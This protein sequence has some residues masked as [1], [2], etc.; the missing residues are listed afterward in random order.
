MAYIPSECTLQEYEEQVYSGSNNHRLYIKYGDTIIGDEANEYASPF[1]SSLKWTR[2]LLDNGS[3]TFNLD[4]FVSQEI[5]LVLN[6]YVIQDITQEI[7]IKIGTYIEKLNKWVY[8]P[9]GKYLVQDNPTT[10][11]NRTTY[12][13][14]DKSKLFD[15]KYNAEPLITSKGGKATLLEILDDICSQA[16]V[17]YVG[18][19]TFSGYN[20]QIGIYDNT[21][22]ARI[23]VS[24]IAEQSGSIATIDRNGNLTFIKIKQSELTT[25]EVSEDIV[26][27]FTDG[28]NFIISKV[29]YESGIIKY[30]KGNDNND[31]LYINSANPYVSNQTQVDNIYN[32]VN[33]LNINSFAI[34][35]IYGNPTFD[36][37]DLIVLNYEGKTYKTFAQYIFTF[38]GVFTSK[39]ETT[40]EHSAKKQNVSVNSEATFRKY[41]KTTIDNIEAKVNIATGKVEQLE[42]EVT[43]IKETNGNNSLYVEDA[44]ESRVLEYGIDGK[45]EQETRSGKNLLKY[46]Y[47]QTTRTQDGI[48]FTDN[49]DG[50]ITING[51]CTANSYTL[52]YLTKDLW[53]YSTEL[54]PLKA[55]TYTFKAIHSNWNIQIALNA[56]KSDGTNEF[57]SYSNESVTKTFTEDVV[58]NIRVYVPTGVTLNNVTIYPQIEKGSTATEFEQYGASPSPEFPSEIKS[59]DGIKNLWKLP[60]TKT[61]NGVTLTNNGDG[62]ITLNGTATANADFYIEDSS[63]NYINGEK[64]YI[65][66]NINKSDVTLLIANYNGNTYANT[67]INS[68]GTMPFTMNTTNDRVRLI[69]RALS[70]KTFNNTKLQIQ[71]E[72]SSVANSFVPYG[73]WLKIKDNGSNALQKINFY[74]WV[75]N[76]NATQEKI[77]DYIKVNMP[78][79]PGSATGIYF[80]TW[81]GRKKG[82]WKEETSYLEGKEVTFSFYA[83]AD[84]ERTIFYL[85]SDNTKRYITLTTEWKRYSV[86]VTN[87]TNK[88]VPVFYCGDTLSTTSYYIKDIMLQK[89]ELIDY[90]P[91]K[92]NISLI[93]MNKP[94]LFDKNNATLNSGVNTSTGVLY[95]STTQFTT[96]YIEIPNIK[97]LNSNGK[98][99][100]SGLLYGA[101]YDENK[102]FLSGVSVSNGII[103]IS[104]TNAKYIRLALL[105]EY[106]DNLVI[107]E[108]FNDY[109]ELCSIGDI[110]DNLIVN[111]DGTTTIEKKIGKV[112]LDGSENWVKGG[113]SFYCNSFVSTNKKVDN[114]NISVISNCF[115]GDTFNNIVAGSN[116][117]TSGNNDSLIRITYD[118]SKTLEQFKSAL[119]TMKP[120]MYYQLEEPY[121][122]DLGTI[123]I[124]LFENINHIN[125][126]DD[127][128]TETRL[129]Y[130]INTTL[131]GTYATKGEL[132]LTNEQFQTTITNEFNSL[133]RQMTSITQTGGAIDLA[134]QSSKDYTDSKN[135][136]L[137]NRIT[138]SENNYNDLNNKYNTLNGKITDMNFSFKT[139]GLT[140]GTSGSEINSKLDN[141]GLKIYNASTLIAIF[142][143]NGSGFKKLIATESIQL[144]NLLIQKRVINTPK[145]NNMEV[146]SFFFN[147]S[148]I[149]NLTDLESD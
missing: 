111:P 134:I 123:D 15:F 146:I 84:S 124:S 67:L 59:V 148:L 121:T 102:A 105:N 141:K 138:N 34:S 88:Q 23:Y 119:N 22:N 46:P 32:I 144:Q 43:T 116:R 58:L 114:N 149:E 81:S 100:T 36:P 45:S 8:I 40:I 117:I 126:V 107:Y 68:N 99:N 55:G 7:D 135:E 140:I 76:G 139:D 72:K 75:N 142:N 62:T 113:S 69:V 5:E 37:W 19:R 10:N 17:N 108:G 71:L 33:G 53:K 112:I 87:F 47:Y 86:T 60:E 77:D 66:S 109:Y 137:D 31:T 92:E 132:E 91:Y 27:G 61:L 85:I 125:L 98:S 6:D 56:Y 16:N 1:A 21:I 18:S 2:R 147:K 49:G 74:N 110:K 25:R 143:Q 48:T 54:L 51:T 3:K 28:D 82:N 70:G 35:K 101:I 131:N 120:T 122:I 26:E 145:A 130:L 14:K 89:G 52:F 9:L 104:N 65:S 12:K 79:T 38:N 42:K 94:N 95:N 24:Y 29:V 80:D 103:T 128:E 39:Y 96:D 90:E 78:T 13:L 115:K 106:L 63:S 30:E 136:S 73:S 20:E 11:E 83:K 133:E 57:L 64:Y 50:S 4:C 93:D 97:I 127:I 118:I 44:L 41:A 129:K